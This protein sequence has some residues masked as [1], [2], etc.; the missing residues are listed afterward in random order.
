MNI[1]NAYLINFKGGYRFSQMPNS[2]KDDLINFITT[3]KQIF[4]DFEKQGDLFLVTRDKTNHK[5]SQFIKKHKLKF[6][7]YP[8]INTKCG[9][10]TEKPEGLSLL[11]KKIN[12]KPITTLTQ[13]DKSIHKQILSN[14][15][16]ELSPDYT[17]RILKTLRINTKK[18]ESKIKN[19][20]VI[21]NDKE[22]ER[23]IFISRPINKTHFVL[24]EPYSSS[25]A[26]ERYVIDSEGKLVEQFDTPE[27]I[28][29]FYKSFKKTI[30]K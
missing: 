26:S 1:D 5:V 18:I 6:E 23:K 20:V 17:G 7:F 30:L 29:E 2:A 4:N 9:L 22:F 27:K 13:L 10:D 12:T 3:K 14:K 21:L 25:N 8:S 16:E 19:G 11:I 28:K 15:V 24:I